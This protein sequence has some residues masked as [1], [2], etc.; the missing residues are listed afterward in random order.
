MAR[1][2]LY[3]EAGKNGLTIISVKKDLRH[4]FAFV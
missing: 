3:D 1:P 2:R 4:I